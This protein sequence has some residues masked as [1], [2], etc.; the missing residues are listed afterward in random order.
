MV[1]IRCTRNGCFHEED[2]HIAW[3]RASDP[4]QQRKQ[5]LSTSLASN[6]PMSSVSVALLPLH[7]QPTDVYTPCALGSGECPPDDEAT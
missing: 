3:G 5:Q 7:D 4:H 6:Q 2:N 1:I